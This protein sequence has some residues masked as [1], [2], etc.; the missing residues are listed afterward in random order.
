MAA[1]RT[2]PRRACLA[3][4]YFRGK[5]TRTR[6]TLRRERSGT[7]ARQ[8]RRD[9]LA[10]GHGETARSSPSP[11]TPRCRSPRSRHAMPAAVRRGDLPQLR[12]VAAQYGELAAAALHHQPRWQRMLEDHSTGRPKT[13]PTTPEACGCSSRAAC[14]GRTACTLGAT[15]VSDLTLLSAGGRTGR[16]G[17]STSASLVPRRVVHAR[18]GRDGLLYADRQPRGLRR[19]GAVQAGGGRTARRGHGDPEGPHPFA[20]GLTQEPEPGAPASAWAS[21]P[22]GRPRR[23]RSEGSPP[24]SRVASSPPD[25]AWAAVRPARGR[26]AGALGLGTGGARGGAPPAR[27]ARRAA[28]PPRAA[29]RRLGEAAASPSWPRA[30]APG[31]SKCARSSSAPIA[32]PAPPGR[33]RWCGSGR[34]RRRR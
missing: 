32:T 1:S 25:R 34:P 24:G 19:A 14:T 31:R 28:R 3:D 7:G 10:A 33:G 12:D 20:A 21:R 15:F 11:R 6:N 29:R 8:H 18:S 16:L 30:A 13:P 4:S 17:G 23:L 22:P 9:R 2:L 26:L 27:L 5:A